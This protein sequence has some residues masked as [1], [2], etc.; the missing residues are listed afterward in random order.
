MSLLIAK[1]FN[2]GINLEDFLGDLADNEVREAVN[3]VLTK[4]GSL[5]KRDGSSEYGTDLNTSPVYAL[6]NYTNDSGTAYKF[7]AISTKIVEYNT[8][9]W[10]T[11]IKTGLTA[12]LYVEMSDIKC[13]TVASVTTGTATAGADYSLTNGGASWTVN[14]YRDYI[15][16]ITS[17]TGVGQVKTILEN[18]ATV[19]YVDGRWDINPDATSVYS[20]HTKSKAVV[21]NNGTD[22]GFKIIST[23]ATDISNLPK[24]TNQVVHNGRLWGILGTKVYWSGLGNGEQWDGYAYIDTG[25]DLVGIGRTRDY[26]VVYSKSKSGVVVGNQ[27]DD[28][29]F[30]WREN[31]HGCM[32]KNSI[33]SYGGYSICLAQDG[34]YAFDGSNEY[35]LSR[36]IKPAINDFKKS[37]FTAISG[38]IFSDKYYLMAAANSTSTVKDVIWVM[39]LIWSNIPTSLGVWTKFEGLN[40]NVMG[41]FKNS[42]GLNDLYFGESDSSKVIQLYDGTFNDQESSIKFDIQTK[43]WDEGAVGIYKRLQSF[44]YE[45]AAQSVESNLEIRKNLDGYGFESFAVVNHLQLGAV[46]DVSLWDVGTFSS[47]D[48]IISRHRPGGRGRTVQYEFFNNVADQPMEIF[49]IEQEYNPYRYH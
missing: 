27:A 39:D 16:K 48:R 47:S 12:D 35:L 36:K 28:F 23:T 4:K 2:G 9:N 33:G 42:N 17:G 3:V 1:Q 21:C 41:V 10:D 8:G 32:A 14:G 7:K 22:T 20:I 30:K 44:F 18:T 19:L 40:A 6:R 5:K 43:E 24:F 13:A 37:L 31:T 38:F 34:V 15:V 46:W 45:G 11:D 49:K 25:E 29:A 26:I